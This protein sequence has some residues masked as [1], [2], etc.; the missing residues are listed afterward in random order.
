MTAYDMF[1]AALLGA[2]LAAAPAV[3]AAGAGSGASVKKAAGPVLQVHRAGASAMARPYIGKPRPPVQVTVLPGASLESGVP[4]RL[5]LLVRSRLP[6]QDIALVAEGDAGLS[7]VGL[8]RAVTAAAVDGRTPVA[9]E[10]AR[11]EISATPV[12]GGTRYLSGLVTYRINGVIQAAP[13]SLPLVVGGAVTVPVA[14]RK[15]G[16]EPIR[17]AAGELVDSMPAET[18]VR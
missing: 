13:F 16:R 9:G 5:M 12:S 7:L 1:V 6:L 14:P 18:T 8:P 11:F 15:P 10:R 2:A 3:S 17:D 4:G